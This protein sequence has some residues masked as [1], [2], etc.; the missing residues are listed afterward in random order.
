MGTFIEDEKQQ[1]RRRHERTQRRFAEEQGFGSAAN[2]YALPPCDSPLE[3]ELGRHVVKYERSGVR[4]IP[5]FEMR[6]YFLDF[7]VREERDGGRAIALECDG[8]GYH[9]LARDRERDQHLLR[10]EKP[11]LERIYRLP[12]KALHASAEA[13]LYVVSRIDGW[14]FDKRGLANLETLGRYFVSQE[15]SDL[16]VVQEEFV[17][18]AVWLRWNSEDDHECERGAKITVRFRRDNGFSV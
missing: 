9:Q 18:R 6:G 13:C 3:D 10:S 17:E 4:V 7:L 8:E 14:M 12:G 1:R 2:L 15:S 11:R 5:Q 16:D